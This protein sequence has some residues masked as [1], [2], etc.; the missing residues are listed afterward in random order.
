MRL[1]P[2]KEGWLTQSPHPHRADR[3]ASFAEAGCDKV[4]F[5]LRPPYRAEIVEPLGRALSPLAER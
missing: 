3:A 1:L 4:I 5:S 2:S